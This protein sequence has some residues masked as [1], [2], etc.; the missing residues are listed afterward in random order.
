MEDENEKY[1]KELE[2]AVRIVHVACALCGKV[3]EKLLA[4]EVVSKEDDSPVTVAGIY[5]YF[6][7]ISIIIFLCCCCELHMIHNRGWKD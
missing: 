2:V 1:A 3:Q 7:S 4:T 6:H 5:F